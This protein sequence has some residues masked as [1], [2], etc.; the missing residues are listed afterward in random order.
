V[1]SVCELELL[2]VRTSPHKEY[3]ELNRILQLPQLR[4]PNSERSDDVAGVA[5]VERRG[6]VV[7]RLNR[8]FPSN[9]RGGILGAELTQPNDTAMTRGP[10]R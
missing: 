9:V 7:S 1:A 4:R 5:Q 6:R 3:N 8:E 10:G 2:P